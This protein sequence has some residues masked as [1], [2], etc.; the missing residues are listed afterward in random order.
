MMGSGGAGE[1]P[2]SPAPVATFADQR[3]LAAWIEAAA[4]EDSAIYATGPA[5]P[6]GH[7]VVQMVQ[8]LTDRGVLRTHLKAR[9]DGRGFDFLAFKRA[10]EKPR[11]CALKR[12]EVKIGRVLELL[13]QRAERG[14]VMPSNAELARACGLKNADAARYQLNKLED[15]GAIRI[16]D[17]G[18][19][20]RRA[21][22]IVA[23]G[24]TT[25]RGRL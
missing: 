18:P 24:Q 5:L 9:A 17:F 10:A 2:R 25:K 8:T 3:A 11:G 4:P 1:R 21:V 13:T 15:R 12:G 16:E 20:E 22:T 6:H 7:P 14:G 23:T 19:N